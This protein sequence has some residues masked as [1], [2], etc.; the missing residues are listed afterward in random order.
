MMNK[1]FKFIITVLTIISTIISVSTPTCWAV[2]AQVFD[3]NC[4][5]FGVKSG[6]EGNIHFDEMPSVEV[7]LYNPTSTDINLTLD[8]KEMIL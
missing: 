7:G 8:Y 1:T 6:T 5:T 4:I 3:E 2:E